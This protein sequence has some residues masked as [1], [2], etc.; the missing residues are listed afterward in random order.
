MFKALSYTIGFICCFIPIILLKAN[1]SC[2]AD[3]LKSTYVIY[4]FEVKFCWGPAVS[5]IYYALSPIIFYSGVIMILLPSIL[6]MSR[7]LKGLLNS[8]LWHI[9]EELTLFA[10]LLQYLVVIWFFASRDSNTIL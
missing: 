6:G 2:I 8:H 10:Y 7:I 4:N 5:S 3:N 1:S 9:L